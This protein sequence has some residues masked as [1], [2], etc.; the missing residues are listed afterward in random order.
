MNVAV[1]VRWGKIPD[2]WWWAG[3]VYGSAAHVCVPWLVMLSGALLLSKK[4]GYISFFQKRVMRMIRPWWFWSLLYLE[5]RVYLGQFTGH[6]SLLR[7][8]W[9][10]FLGNFWLLPVLVGLYLITP[11]LR[12]WLVVARQRDVIYAICLWFVAVSINPFIVRFTQVG[13]VIALLPALKYL[14]YYLLGYLVARR[15]WEKS[16]EKTTIIVFGLGVGVT[17]VITFA[18]SGFKAGFDEWFWDYTSLG[19][20]TASVGGFVG[21]MMLA[22]RMEKRVGI[23]VKQVVTNM[24]ELSLGIYLVHMWILEIFKLGKLGVTIDAFLI[25]PAVGVGFV[26]ALVFGVSYVVMLVLKK[27]P[28]LGWW[29]S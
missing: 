23:S 25:H 19:M 11:L 6:E 17:S 16:W 18:L 7:F 3:N 21:M 14:G 28:G 13:K 22:R 15:K 4:E 29:V 27:V 26:A 10:T 2:D 24:S 5:W 8:W 1:V 9:Q 20:I 12:Q